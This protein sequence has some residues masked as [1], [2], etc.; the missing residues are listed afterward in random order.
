MICPFYDSCNGN[1]LRKTEEAAVEVP[2][3]KSNAINNSETL[4]SDEN[5][6]AIETPILETKYTFYDRIYDLIDDNDSQNTYEFASMFFSLF[7]NSF[8]DIQI[9][10]KEGIQ[11]NQ[12]GGL[13]FQIKNFCFFVIII[14]TIIN[15]VLSFNKK[16]KLITKFSK[17]NLV[18][19]SITIICLFLDGLFEQISQ[20]KWGYYCFVVSNIMIYINCRKLLNSTLP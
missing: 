12:Y 4:V 15:L 17:I 14:F 20:I 2:L 13:F 19:I 16:I 8:Q 6:I 7:E 3:E 9:S 18:L 11:K 5:N 1:G 10:V